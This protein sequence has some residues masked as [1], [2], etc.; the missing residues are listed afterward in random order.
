MKN[1]IDDLTA[2]IQCEEVY[3]V[4][5]TA[6]AIFDTMRKEEREAMDSNEDREDEPSDNMTDAEA[7]AD[8]LASAGMGT[9]EDYEHNLIDDAGFEG[10]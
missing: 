2:E 3:S 6:Q 7:D 8:T 10:F 1:E 4:E 9:D 5:D